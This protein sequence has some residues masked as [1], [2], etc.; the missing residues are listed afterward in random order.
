MFSVAL[1]LLLAAGSRVKCEQLTQPKSETVQPGQRLTITCQVTYSL[2][3][4]WTG[5]IRQPAGKGLE[6][7]GSRYTGE[8]AYKDSLKNKF[9][10]DLDTSSKTVTLIGQNMQ[11]D[12]TGMYYCA[13]AGA[14]YSYGYFDYWG[15]GTQVT[16]TSATST[17]PTVFPLVPC[18]TESGE[19]VTLGCLATGF[20]P[21]AVTFSW[22][23]GGAA[24]TDFIQYPAVQK[25]N[26]YTGV[27]QVRVR[28]QDWNAQQ[29][30]QCAVTHAAGN[31]QTIVTPPPPPFKQ[32]PTLKAFSSSSDEDD[33]YTASC[34][35]K[36][37][38]PKTHNL[39]WQKNGVDVASTIDLTE[40]KNAAGKTL[41]NAASFLTVNSSDLNDQTRFTCV[42]TGGEDG[43][44]N[45]TVI[46]KKNQCPGCVTSNVKVVISGPTTEDM[47]VRKKGTITCA[48]TV[49][50]DEPQITW[51]DEKLGDIASNPVTKVEDNGNTYVSKLDITYDEWTRGVTRFCVVHHEDLIEP[52]REPY[53]R[54]FGGNPQR[55]SVFMLPPL[56]QTNKAEVTLTCFV[57]DFFPKEVFV[58]WLVD[59]EEA[60]SIYAF[61]TTEPIENNGFYSAYGQ[62]FVSL[63]QWQRDDAVYSCVVYHES[64]VN[65]TRAI[66]RSIGYRTFDK[67]R[68]DLNMNINQ[69]SK[70]SLQ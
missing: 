48:V 38:A 68:I 60:D 53:K 30:L 35:A 50:K 2:S 43:S 46:Y 67:N 23:K 19:M 62:L 59:D 26:V 20:N 9:S 40:S 21:P 44:L 37:F 16:V 64:V 54:D 32:N 66:V 70:C 57:K 5:W 11:P 10:I 65:T 36:E 58:S 8:A 49:Q 3:T 24:L 33:T 1:L 18:G 17:A 61:N 14:A 22:T 63:H 69:D 4:S 56:E 45:K 29:N 31:A 51:E 39:K 13:K 42:F 12:D 25:G 34:F 47:L 7:I 27:S 15:K 28:R 41:Y 55:P 6:W 52:L